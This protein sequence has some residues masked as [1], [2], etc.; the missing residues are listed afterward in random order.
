MTEYFLKP[1]VKTAFSKA[2]LKFVPPIN[3]SS[4]CA[5]GTLNSKLL[6][7]IMWYELEARFKTT[8]DRLH[9]FRDA[10]MKESLLNSSSIALKDPVCGSTRRWNERFCTMKLRNLPHDLKSSERFTK[11]TGVLLPVFKLSFIHYS[12]R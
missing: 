12:V 3:Y 5:D 10:F 1:N 9:F 2:I 4:T 11:G 6:F 8:G 7:G